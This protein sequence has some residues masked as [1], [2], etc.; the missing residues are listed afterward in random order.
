LIYVDITVSIHPAGVF[1]SQ[2]LGEFLMPYDE[3]QS[4]SSPEQALLEFF[5]STYEVGA[6]GPRSLRKKGAMKSVNRKE[7]KECATESPGRITFS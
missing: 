1:Y 4:S 2:E 6:V 5:Q 7:L 3:V